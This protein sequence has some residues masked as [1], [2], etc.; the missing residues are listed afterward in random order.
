M[1]PGIGEGAVGEIFEPI[2]AAAEMDKGFDADM[3]RQVQRGFGVLGQGFTVWGLGSRPPI[4]WIEDRAVREV[5]AGSSSSTEGQGAD[6][7]RQ[8]KKAEDKT[9]DLWGRFGVG[10]KQG[11]A[12]AEIGK[13]L[14]A[15]AM[16]TECGGSEEE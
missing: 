7:Y 11:G 1:G 3:Y 14:D 8:V 13:K 5:R 15:D 10:W 4:P 6:T 16:C 2:T 9:G 12:G